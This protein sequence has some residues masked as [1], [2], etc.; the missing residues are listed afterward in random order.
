[1]LLRDGDR[2]D[3]PRIVY[4]QET[5]EIVAEE[6]VRAVLDSGQSIDLATDD[7]AR[8]QPIRIEGERAEWGGEPP[9]VTFKG[10]VR[11]WQGENFLVSDELRGEPGSSR[12]QATG[13]VKT[14]WRPEAES[15]A[16]AQALP[17]APLEVTANE[18][19]FDRQQNLIVYSGAARA[20]QLQKSLRC[21]EI[22]LF[23]AEEGGFEKMICEGSVQMQDAE[24]GNSVIG[25]RATYRPGEEKVEVDGSPVV[26]RDSD[27]TQIQGKTLIYDFATAT[28]QVR[29][30][31]Q[32]PLLDDDGR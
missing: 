4:N 18:M 31:P 29:S 12:V 24:S 6:S 15:D 13:S 23:L 1:M 19:L 27:G 9:A 7:A 21:N 17:A 2:L 30:V 26:L 22:R 5:E 14:V 11:A 28:A 3:A 25:E 10:Q 20:V 16:E 32:E 8:D